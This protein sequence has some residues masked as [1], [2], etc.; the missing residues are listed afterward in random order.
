MGLVPAGGA[1]GFPGESARGGVNPGGPGLAGE[2]TLRR[3]VLQVDLPD[4]A[5]GEVHQ[6]VDAL[7]SQ[8]AADISH[9]LA[10]VA[11]RVERSASMTGDP[12]AGSASHGE[13]AVVARASRVPV[14]EVDLAARRVFVG[15]Q[16][17]QLA[18]KE[19]EILRML[20][21]QP[22]EVV[23]RDEIV[24]GLDAAN[25]E[26]PAPRTI[27]VHV[28]RIRAKLDACGDCI[29]TVR[30]VGYRFNPSSSARVL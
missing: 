15:D 30:G 22:G 11:S 28:H 8:V 19:F 10:G 20:L 9:S 4:E 5:G 25:N 2:G 14:L 26:R 27:D 23:T 16:S 1:A 13:L 21:R 24:A 3:Y 17:V 29:T 18:F 7:L 12:D 6:R